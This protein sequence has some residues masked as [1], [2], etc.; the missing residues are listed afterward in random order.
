LWS[1]FPVGFTKVL[2]SNCATVE[3]MKICNNKG[4]A[5]PVQTYYWP[6]GFQDVEAL[7]FRDNRHMKAVTLS[8]LG[9]GCLYPPGN[10][11]GTLFR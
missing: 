3:E 6:K 2:A 4:K 10:T 5:V 1:P 8:A 9:T 11:R 7:R